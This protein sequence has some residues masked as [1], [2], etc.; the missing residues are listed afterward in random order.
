MPT[1]LVTG[2]NRGIGLATVRQLAASGIE[3]WLGARDPA[4]ARAC[5][6]ALAAEGFAG[7][8]PVT[9]DVADTA[10]IAAC[11]RR[12]EA[13]G[14]HIDIL[15]N[16]A[17]L[18]LQGSVLD[19]PEACF[20]QAMAV[21]AFGALWCA[22]AFMPGMLARGW[23]RIV[24]LASGYGCFSTGLDGPAPY[25]L[26]KAALNAITL[27]LARA[28]SGDVKVNAV[29]PGWV[30][31]RMGGPQ[32]PRAVEDAAADVVWAATLPADGPHGCLLRRRAVVPW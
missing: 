2:G 6:D 9:I 19:A 28:S 7:V 3:V 15:I 21:N 23:G 26:S 4:A 14:G 11:A 31:T 27:M 30:R 8:H 25:S 10:S 29:D 18:Y 20:A 24:N 22:R 1:A 32:A 12:I 16:N 17:G 13:T 5:A